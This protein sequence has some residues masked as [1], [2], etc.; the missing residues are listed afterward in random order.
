MDSGFININDSKRDKIINAALEEFAA[1][2]YDKAS[3]N[4]IVKNAGISRGLLYHYFK[5]KEE[6]YD[7]LKKYA[8]K[9]LFDKLN[10][11][12]DWEEGDIFERIKQIA[13]VK[14]ELSRRYPELFDFVIGIFTR[15][16]RVSSLKEAYKFYEELGINVQE[17]FGKIYCENI[18]FSKFKE[19]EKIAVS[20]NIIRWTIEKWTEEFLAKSAGKF[21]AEDLEP[22]VKEL[23]VYTHALKQAFYK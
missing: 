3:T 10:S 8:V 13:F 23:D 11:A 21:S 18:D 9:T 19:P 20:L 4:E 14:I 15:D 7:M 22:L 2:G 16:N 12:I 5:D 6:L 1:N 17:L